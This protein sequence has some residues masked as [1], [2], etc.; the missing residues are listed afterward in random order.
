MNGKLQT[1]RL[2]KAGKMKRK[3]ESM[4]II[5][6]DSKRIVHQEYVMAGQTAIFNILL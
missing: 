6:L 5:L 3:V 1:Q 4:F 2:K